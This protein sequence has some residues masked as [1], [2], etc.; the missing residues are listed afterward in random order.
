MGKTEVLEIQKNEDRMIEQKNNFQRSFLFQNS[1]KY[2]NSDLDLLYCS[3]R[4]NNSK[5]MR[6]RI[7]LDMYGA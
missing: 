2:D 6:S 1:S 7:W 5:N 3:G 4:S